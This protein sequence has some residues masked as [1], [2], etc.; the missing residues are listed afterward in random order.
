MVREGWRERVKEKGGGEGG[1]GREK[2]EFNKFYYY[3]YQ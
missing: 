2:D 3:P 1:R